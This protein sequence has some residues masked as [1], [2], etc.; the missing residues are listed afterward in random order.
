M[1]FL[2]WLFLLLG[3][4]GLIAG[5]VLLAKNI[6]DINQLVA[7]ASANRSTGF[8][9]PRR[10]VVMGV[11]VTAVAGLLL[12]WGLGLPGR[13]SRSVRNQYKN[14]LEARGVVVDPEKQN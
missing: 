13:T 11:A 12:G 7:V 8:V 9:N 10:Q 1:K 6:I 4:A 5:G 14:D 2:K 3:L